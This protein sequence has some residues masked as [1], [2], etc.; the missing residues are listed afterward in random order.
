[1]DEA[2]GIT[3][4][5]DDSGNGRPRIILKES[6]YCVWSTVV[7]QVLREKKLWGH[8]MGTAVTPTTARV[9]APAMPAVA[10]TPRVDPVVGVAEV[11]Q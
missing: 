8:V 7:E 10:A 1:M 11:T 6:T 4:S 9:V 5:N 3:A 2:Y